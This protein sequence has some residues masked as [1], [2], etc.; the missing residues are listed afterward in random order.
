M[1]D[2]CIKKI[3][4]RFTF[5]Y[6]HNEF[7]LDFKQFDASVIVR[8][9]KGTDGDLLI[10]ASA[11][12][13]EPI[14]SDDDGNVQADLNDSF[15]MMRASSQLDKAI[16]QFKQ[17]TSQPSCVHPTKNCKKNTIFETVFLVYIFSSSDLLIIYF[18]FKLIIPRYILY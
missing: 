10:S 12:I 1:C 13:N 5:D 18:F 16:D 8:K 11:P 4:K 2:C 14:A 17:G 7:Y 15:E 6:V 9:F 3:K